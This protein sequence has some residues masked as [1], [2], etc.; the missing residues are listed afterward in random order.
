[1]PMTIDEIKERLGDPDAT[2]TTDEVNMLVDHIEHKALTDI[3]NHS[4]IAIASQHA[5]EQVQIARE[6]ANALMDAW[7]TG[8]VVRPVSVEEDDG[9]E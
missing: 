2:F 4:R 1:M 9:Q 5:Q 6:C 8:M 7:E 3:Y